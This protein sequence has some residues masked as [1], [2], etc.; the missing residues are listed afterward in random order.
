VASR[1]DVSS[2]SETEEKHKNQIASLD[3]DPG[4]W[5]IEITRQALTESR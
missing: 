1:V 4:V 2:V 5:D 3:S